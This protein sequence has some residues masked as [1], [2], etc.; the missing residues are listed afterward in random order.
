MSRKERNNKTL[1]LLRAC[2]LTA[3]KFELTEFIARSIV[4]E[5]K[6]IVH[7]DNILLKT[8]AI[9]DF[10]RA[11]GE[12]QIADMKRYVIVY[13]WLLSTKIQPESS[14]DEITE[15]DYDQASM[16]LLLASRKKSD[17]TLG[18]KGGK[19]EV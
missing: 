19:M 8:K 5:N 15:S 7:I 14:M 6:N 9:L 18:K 13:R 2:A 4:D 10:R 1:Q 3:F 16:S 11:R 12:I 17:A